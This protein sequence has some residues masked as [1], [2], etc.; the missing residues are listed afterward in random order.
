MISHLADLATT[1]LLDLSA[2][3]EG[4][5]IQYSV[6][7]VNEFVP[8]QPVEPNDI[9][10]DSQILQA[11][12]LGDEAEVRAWLSR[13]NPTSAGQGRASRVFLSIAEE[14]P[15]NVLNSLI[16]SGFVDIK[17]HNDINGRNCLHSAA[18]S[19]NLSLLQRGIFGGASIVCKDNYGRMPLHYA[20]LKGHNEVIRLLV[21]SNPETVDTK[22]QDGFTPL[23]HAIVN[24]QLACVQTLLQSGA[25]VDPVEEIDNLP[26]RIPLNLACQ[27]SSLAV[28]KLLLNERVKIIADAE[29]LY[30]QHVLARYGRD[31]TMILT[32]KEYGVDLD[33]HDRLYQW[34]PLIH[35]A[36][37]GHF[38]A[39][40][41]LLACGVSTLLLDEKGHSALYY[42]TLEGHDDCMRTLAPQEVPD[43]MPD[44]AISPSKAPNSSAAYEDGSMIV[45]SEPEG[46]PPIS[47]P[48]PII[49]L[50][51]YGHNFL[52]SKTFVVIT[53]NGEGS[54]AMEFYDNSK[55]PAARLMITSKSSD[56][57]PR[58]L[59]LPV[60][61]E[62]KT[63]SF[64]IDNLETFSI[65]FDIFPS[66]GSKV[67]GRTVASSKI[68][69]S[70]SNNEG[71]WYL[72]IFDPRLQAIG[73]MTFHYQVL[74][75]FPG[76]PLEMTNFATYWKATSQS[77]TNQNPFVTG[78]SL[79]GEYVRLFIQM[80]A[81]SEII[82]CSR[83]NIEFH[84]L[85]IPIRS[86]SYAELKK[87]ISSNDKD[88]TT[89]ESVIQDKLAREPN[90]VHHMLVDSYIT[91][92]QALKLL[93]LSVRLELHI[94][95]SNRSDNEAS[96]WR[97]SHNV[98]NLADS[99]LSIVFE[100][101]KQLRQ[102]S[103]EYMRS[104][105]FSSFNQNIC[106]AL[107]WK[108]PNCR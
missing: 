31:T 33:Q 98:N 75:P 13:L 67:I 18:I 24:A 29:G 52:D 5:K 27:H 51:R 6:A 108:Q 85:K 47:L 82:L 21:A 49:P 105:I 62:D 92:R 16:D 87:V 15:N 45:D 59:T 22:D 63:I 60:Q 102:Q 43:K 79:S 103:N 106:L 97:I 50:K 14:A 10:L 94:I 78:S 25:L 12:T 41:C 89:I 83:A 36:N 81:D 80:T 19:G 99:I 3:A 39:L 4:E 56:L 38:E 32:L 26:N 65:D 100:H 72:E 35:A 46:I 71:K 1:N 93:P 23:I 101:S 68:F 96:P 58:S 53:L 61:D 95:H 84:G 48:P 54:D 44:K 40:K 76:I 57:V 17:Q 37:E 28:I 20:C 42:A 55:Y 73:R 91:L 2:W 70:N 11:A 66:F 30:P 9:D 86:I 64:Q 69:T 34:T 77:D 90:Q 88:D 74:K 107:N 8:D 7:S 104:L